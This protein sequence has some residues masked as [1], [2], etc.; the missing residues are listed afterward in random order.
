[1]QVSHLNNS[2]NPA[3]V[4]V[5]ED[6][7]LHGNVRGQGDR[8]DKGREKKKKS[9]R[10]CCRFLSRGAE[11]VS[12]AFLDAEILRL[13]TD[14][15]HGNVHDECVSCKKRRFFF[16]YLRLCLSLPHL[17]KSVK[18]QDTCTAAASKISWIAALVLMFGDLSAAARA[19]SLCKTCDTVTGGHCQAGLS[20][21]VLRKK[22]TN[23][24]RGYILTGE[25][26]THWGFAAEM[27]RDRHFRLVRWFKKM[28]AGVTV[29]DKTNV[30]IQ[31]TMKVD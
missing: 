17:S 18:Y 23:S 21:R 16:F 30:K 13:Y 10:E 2:R 19:V 4:S 25:W 11:L 3:F 6:L 24:E 9:F 12:S 26:G 28:S 7:A 20:Q 22:L 27:W 15:N 14:E 5:L 8:H 29:Q 31:L 1:M